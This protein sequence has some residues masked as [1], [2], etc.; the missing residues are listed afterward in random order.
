MRDCLVLGSLGVEYCR[1]IISVSSMFVIMRACIDDVMHRATYSWA[2]EIGLGTREVC[3]GMHSSL[4]HI[5]SANS[6]SLRRR[7]IQQYKK[8]A[9]IIA[10]PAK[11]LTP[12][13]T[14]NCVSVI[15]SG[16]THASIGYPLY[17]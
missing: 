12:I 5:L 16:R 4:C 10:I 7:L 15:F 13:T 6:S 2:Q 8:R 3:V 17:L 11:A 14:P 1:H 9:M